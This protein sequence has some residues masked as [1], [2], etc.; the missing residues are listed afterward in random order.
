[1]VHSV[2]CPVKS[3]NLSLLKS[4]SKVIVHK[5]CVLSRKKTK[6]KKGVDSKRVRGKIDLGEKN[7]TK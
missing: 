6:K 1:M 3:I 4:L 2:R 5:R 7:L